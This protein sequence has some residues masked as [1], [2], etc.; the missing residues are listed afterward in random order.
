V[1]QDAL[2]VFRFSAVQ[3]TL[4]VIQDA[5][6]M[7]LFQGGRQRRSA[8]LPPGVP[9]QSSHE[10][11]Q[12]RADGFLGPGLI[13]PHVPSDLSRRRSRQLALQHVQ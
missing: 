1:F 13:R 4:Q 5:A 7:V 8:L 11:R 9:G 12:C 6:V 10:G 2:P 3:E